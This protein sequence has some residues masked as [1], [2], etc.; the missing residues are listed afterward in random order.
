M[1]AISILIL[2]AAALSL[3]G[4]VVGV[5]S[6]WHVRV[7]AGSVEAQMESTRE[8]SESRFESLREQLDAQ[9]A[10]LRELERQPALTL[11]PGVPK[12]GMNVVK[13]SQA[14]RMHRRG[15][16]PDQIA[17]ALELP[18]QEVELLLKVHTIVIS[19]V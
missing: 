19:S 12:P 16:R 2:T 3:T 15:D 9:A 14:L 10:L 5:F 18:R 17:A 6:V 8:E 11:A 7:L 4:I 13:R 1:T